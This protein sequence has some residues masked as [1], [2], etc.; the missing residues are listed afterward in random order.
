ML[1]ASTARD[2]RHVRGHG[3]GGGGRHVERGLV[4][5]KREYR[6]ARSSAG[7]STVP[8]VA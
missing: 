8:T 5:M 2:G 1:A 7:L 4:R 3:D 6:A